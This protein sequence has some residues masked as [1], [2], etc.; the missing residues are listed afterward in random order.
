M[1]QRWKRGDLQAAEFTALLDGLLEVL[2]AAEVDLAVI[3][4]AY[5]LDAT[6]LR[7][8]VRCEAYLATSRA[9][10][11]S[12]RAELAARVTSGPGNAMHFDA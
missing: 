12:A 11:T 5:P 6:V 10:L 3:A 4:G 7:A 2:E 8:I 9:A 1:G